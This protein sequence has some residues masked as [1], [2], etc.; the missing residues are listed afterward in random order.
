MLMLYFTPDFLEFFKQNYSKFDLYS[1]IISY[2]NTIKRFHHNGSTAIV[3]PLNDIIINK[4]LI[5]QFK[6]FCSILKTNLGEI[7]TFEEYLIFS[8]LGIEM[9]KKD[10]KLDVNV[11][12]I[13]NES[14]TDIQDMIEFQNNWSKQTLKSFNKSLKDKSFFILSNTKY[15]FDQLTHVQ[16]LFF[17]LV[18]FDQNYPKFQKR[19][20]KFLS[21]L[22]LFSQLNTLYLHVGKFHSSQSDCWFLSS[23]VSAV[24]EIKTLVHFG[25]ISDNVIHPDFMN[26]L[27]T[28]DHIKALNIHTPSLTKI[29]TISS[30]SSLSIAIN[31]NESISLQFDKYKKLNK[32]ELSCAHIN[33]FI[34][35]LNNLPMLTDL[36]INNFTNIKRTLK[37]LP[38]TLKLESLVIDKVNN[39]ALVEFEKVLIHIFSIDRSEDSTLKILKLP[40]SFVNLKTLPFTLTKLEIPLAMFSGT[41]KQLEFLSI[42]DELNCEKL[43]KLTEIIQISKFLKKLEMILPLEK[44]NDFKDLLI[45]FFLQVSVTQ[46]TNMKITNFENFDL[47]FDFINCSPTLFTIQYSSDKCLIIW[48]NILTHLNSFDKVQLQNAS[49]G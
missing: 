39:Q 6:E 28:I 42:M 44:S 25:I 3:L 27:T 30:L 11:P 10:I 40:I 26:R 41:F 23:I 31:N 5:L 7:K 33:D 47:F 16:K 17:N 35:I 2:C 29:S 22:S 49:I 48:K 15:S 37:V 32:L 1:L 21:R 20:N 12:T 13:T 24:N 8:P 4:Q 36:K 9:I 14:L 19:F 43:K 34:R 46:I 18:Q 45:Q 38:K